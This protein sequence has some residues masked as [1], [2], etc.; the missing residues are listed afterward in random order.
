[1][2]CTNKLFAVILSAVTLLSMS[3]CG[4]KNTI[5][6]EYERN[7]LSSSLAISTA[8]S[9]YVYSEPF[10]KDLCVDD[11]V[12]IN[13]VNLQGAYAAGLFDIN[14]K[15]VLYGK[16]MYED[17]TPASITKLLTTLVVLK[18]FDMNKKLIFTPNCKI[19][20]AGAQLLGLSEGDTLTTEQ[21]LNILLLFSANDVAMMLANNYE[22]GYDAFIKKMNEEAANLG[23]THTHFVNPHG[24][25]EE[26]HQTCVYDLYLILNELVK[27]DKF[28]EIVS[29]TGYATSYTKADGSIKTIELSNTNQFIKGDREVP[30]G[31]K[32][33]GGK[34]GTT[35]AA[36]K[37][38]II[39]FEDSERNPY[40]ACILRDE[41]YDMLYSDMTNL[42]S[43]AK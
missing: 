15:T 5:P 1:M 13:T 37:C 8:K 6:C 10:A 14:D 24:L 23:A 32:V 43:N 26:N 29:Q 18:E 35:E 25:T 20:E 17:M 7:T 38:L 31:Y 41:D 3:A 33:L 12:Y 19:T 4:S 40:I 9:L 27:Y 11:K 22:G 16:N 36:G 28:K 21:A 39:Y 42:I 30:E 34:T 2:K